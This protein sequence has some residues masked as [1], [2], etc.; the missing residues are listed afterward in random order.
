MVIIL[1]F[2]LRLFDCLYLAIFDQLIGDL[3]AFEGIFAVSKRPKLINREILL[4]LLIEIL[5]IPA[6]LQ[7]VALSINNYY[8]ILHSST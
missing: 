1:A 7:E 8:I 6:T 2:L 4:T 5:L 3:L